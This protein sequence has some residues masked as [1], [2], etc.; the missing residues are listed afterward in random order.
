MNVQDYIESGSIESCV[1]QLASEREQRELDRLCA[2]YPEI[3]AARTVF[4]LSLE[5]AAMEG[6]VQP[7]PF[8]RD[9]VLSVIHD[10]AGAGNKTSKPELNTS[11][12]TINWRKLSLAAA[13]ILLAGSAA[14]NIYLYNQ[15]TTTHNRYTTLL[16]EQQQMADANKAIQAKLSVSEKDLAMMKDP[17]MQ[18]VK[19]G[20]MNKTNSMGTIYWD[21]L[22]KNV[23]LLVNHLPKPAAGQQYQL[24]AIVDGQ[25][26]DAGMIQ[27]DSETAL[28]AMKK[29]MRAEAFAIT[30]EKEG[31]SPSPTLTALY[32]MGKV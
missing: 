1:L 14:L 21:S 7:A 17:R 22:S 25:P 3:Q 26:V 19:L 13:L 9:S 20:D 32:V 5:K 16:A 24:W 6:A 23:Y 2:E 28:L 27:M 12:G 29:I 30:L 4:E 31:G 10:T 8:I 15:Y 11:T 18:M